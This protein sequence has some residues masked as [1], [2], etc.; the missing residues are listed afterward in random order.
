MRFDGTWRPLRVRR[1]KVGVAALTGAGVMALGGGVAV[2]VT[3]IPGAGGV[4]YG[5]FTTSTGALRVVPQGTACSSKETAISWNQVGPTGAQGQ[6]GPTGSPGPQGAVG[7][8]GLMGPAGPQG[9]PGPTG[10]AGAV[11]PEGPQGPTGAT[12]PPGMRF[13]GPWDSTVGY[14][15]N[16][17]VEYE[18]S[19][20]IA[21]DANTN[22][23]PGSTSPSVWDLVANQGNTGAVG[24]VGPQGPQ[25]AQGPQGPAGPTG[26]TGPQGA[27]GAQGPTGPQGPAG[28]SFGSTAVTDRGTV[29]MTQTACVA[30][31]QTL[32]AVQVTLS[33]PM[34]LFVSGGYSYTDGSTNGSGGG[35]YEYY[36]SNIQLTA[37]S[38]AV[39]QL[40]TQYGQ[41]TTDGQTHY[42]GNS[43]M[44]GSPSASSPAG[45]MVIPAGSYSLDYQL[46]VTNL[47]S[48]ACPVQDWTQSTNGSVEVQPSLTWM[49]V[50]TT[51]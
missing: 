39:A 45:P 50:G 40:R 2:A 4:I 28:P 5:C 36:Y 27:T 6:A 19:T 33:K 41:A 49:E 44:L 30:P 14:Q 13:L 24:P 7:P 32:L 34:Y 16:D 8:Q 20:F 1:V 10:S 48:N 18:G 23:A 21:L 31:G 29:R 15:A 12:G 25:G 26:A 38:G 51:S 22:V 17:A 46:E 47:F 43:G 9:V 11:G 42:F 35:V 37:G 3:G